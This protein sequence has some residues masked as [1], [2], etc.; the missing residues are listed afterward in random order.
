MIHAVRS[1]AAF[2]QIKYKK[3]NNTE[4]NWQNVDLLRQPQLAELNATFVRIHDCF[5]DEVNNAERILVIWS[6]I[7][8]SWVTDDVFALIYMR[9]HINIK[10]K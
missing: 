4:F 2:I 9:Y 10:R 6:R 5:N 1:P 3:S 8:K 7:K